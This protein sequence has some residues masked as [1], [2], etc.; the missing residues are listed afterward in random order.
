MA[1]EKGE[2]V[3]WKWWV[4]G[5]E[6]Q[7]HFRHNYFSMPL[8]NP[9]GWARDRTKSGGTVTFKVWMVGV[10]GRWHKRDGKRAAERKNIRRMQCS[11]REQ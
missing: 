10:A 4:K 5:E 3:I 2:T 8:G 7:V 6:S 11:A 1:A 9:D